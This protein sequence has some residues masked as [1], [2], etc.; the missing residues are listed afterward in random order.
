LLLPAP[1]EVLFMTWAFVRL[2]GPN[3]DAFRSSLWV[4]LA[5]LSSW[6]ELPWYIGG[7]FNVTRFS[8]ERSRDVRVS[9]ALMEFLNF[10]SEQGL[11][12]LPLAG[13]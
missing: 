7:D 10:I 8:V 9:A 5:G 4:E 12:D 13:G 3:I 1:L 11:M 6:W 2:Y